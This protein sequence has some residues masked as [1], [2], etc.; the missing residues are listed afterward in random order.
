MELRSLVPR[1]C[2]YCGVGCGLYLVVNDGTLTGLEYMKEHPTNEG[3]LCPKGNACLDVVYHRERI[4]YP[5]KKVNGKFERI[6]W[7][8]ALDLV[9]ENLVLADPVPPWCS[10][11]YAGAHG[12]RLHW[13]LPAPYPDATFVDERLRDGSL[14]HVVASNGLAFYGMVPNSPLPIAG[15][16][17]RRGPELADGYRVDVGP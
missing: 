15:I 3:A 5:M 16:A 7:D 8:A 10:A 4:L 13:L 12:Q 2:P 14:H 17:I 1:I 6:S 9:A 11:D